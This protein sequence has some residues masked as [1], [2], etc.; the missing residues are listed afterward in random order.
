[1]YISHLYPANARRSHTITVKREQ[2]HINDINT[3]HSNSISTS[4]S[5][6]SFIH[7][8]GMKISLVPCDLMVVITLTT[9]PSLPLTPDSCR[10]SLQC[11]KRFGF[12]VIMSCSQSFRRI[13]ATVYANRRE[14]GE[15]V[16]MH[17][18][19]LILH[20]SGVSFAHCSSATFSDASSISILIFFSCPRRKCHEPH[21]CNV[22][23]CTTAQ[24]PCTVCV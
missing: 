20:A 17:F 5:S 14:T 3:I 6:S 22:C 19:K 2:S 4:T 1:M 21:A 7:H 23:G 8:F 10:L 12:V 11:H 9:G 24:S 18:S 16:C 13:A 15:T